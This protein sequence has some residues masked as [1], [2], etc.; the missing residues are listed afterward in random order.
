MKTDQ[1]EWRRKFQSQRRLSKYSGSTHSNICQDSIQIHYSKVSSINHL[2]MEKVHIFRFTKK[3]LI[4]ILPYPDQK[5]CTCIWDLHLYLLHKQ[6]CAKQLSRCSCPI[7]K[8]AWKARSWALLIIV[9]GP[10]E[11]LSQIYLPPEGNTL[12]HLLHFLA[13]YELWIVIATV[14]DSQQEKE[15]SAIFLVF[16]Q[17]WSEHLIIMPLNRRKIYSCF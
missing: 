16:C 1:C 7:S 9:S 13:T 15:P 4:L 6:T 11:P 5:Q 12:L 14:T 3:K 8:V 2:I 17:P 10:Q